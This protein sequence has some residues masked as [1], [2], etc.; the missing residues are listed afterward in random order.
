MNINRTYVLVIT[1]YG[2]KARG[3]PDQLT[4]NQALESKCLSLRV[5]ISLLEAWQFPADELLRKNA[6]ND[7]QNFNFN[8]RLN[9][10]SDSVQSP[11]AA[12]G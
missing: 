11:V 7:I 2:G 8:S 4:R 10:S 5:A 3:I 12:S 9:F 6:C 1:Y